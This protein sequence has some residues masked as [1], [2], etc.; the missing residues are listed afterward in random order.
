MWKAFCCRLSKEAREMIDIGRGAAVR[1]VRKTKF[2]HSSTFCFCFTKLDQNNWESQNYFF[3]CWT[4]VNF[5]FSKNLDKI[6][7]E[8]DKL[9]TEKEKKRIARKKERRATLI[10]GNIRAIN[11]IIKRFFLMKMLINSNELVHQ[12]IGHFH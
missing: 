8:N 3:S 10:L 1:S 5:D 6:N 9:N 11:F 4:N 12:Q 7:K 2:F